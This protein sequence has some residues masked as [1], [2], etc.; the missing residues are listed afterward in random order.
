MARKAAGRP[1]MLRGETG[2]DQ[3]D[4]R[5]TE[6]GTWQCRLLAIVV[7]GKDG[8]EPRVTQLRKGILDPQQKALHQYKA[9]HHYIALSAL[10][11]LYFCEAQ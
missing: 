6:R 1:G 8:M 2:G 3:A 11:S 9:L 10:L 7:Y 5:L 4:C